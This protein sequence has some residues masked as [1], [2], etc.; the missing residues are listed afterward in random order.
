M[1]LFFSTKPVQQKPKINN[2]LDFPTLDIKDSKTT[3]D[4]TKSEIQ[5]NTNKTIWGNFNK[6]I[7]NQE[8]NDDSKE[9]VDNKSNV[10]EQKIEYSQEQL[11]YFEI[12][13]K[14]KD[15]YLEETIIMK[16]ISSDEED[17]FEDSNIEFVVPKNVNYPT[18]N[19]ENV[20][21]DEDF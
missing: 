4:T 17:N 11:L 6:E 2:A 10:P 14:N 21:L 5:M 19:E 15:L 20:I 13:A 16:D 1:Y 3:V 7:L 8:I 12:K 9:N 18:E